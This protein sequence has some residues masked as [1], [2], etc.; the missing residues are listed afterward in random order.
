MT[1]LHVKQWPVY[2]AQRQRDVLDRG[3]R[4]CIGTKRDDMRKGNAEE[5]EGESE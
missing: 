5:E 2:T 3:D 4:G 1:L